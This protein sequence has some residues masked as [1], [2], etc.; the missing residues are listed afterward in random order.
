ME[1]G[2]FPAWVREHLPEPTEIQRMAWPLLRGGGSAL[3]V[4]PTGT[5]KTEAAMVPILE[6]LVEHPSLPISVVYVS[7]LRALNRDLEGRLLSMA[8]SAGL[9]AKAR[10][11]DTPSSERTRQSRNP[12]NL[13]ITTPET[14]QL[15]LIGKNLRK[16]LANARVVVIDEVHELASSDRGAQLALSLER[17]ERLAGRRVRR[18]GLSA[19]VSN[20][21]ELARFISYK[22]PA[23]IVVATG[24]KRF[25]ISVTP[26]VEPEEGAATARF[27]GEAD[28]RFLSAATGV[29]Q[30]V[31]AHE[32]TLVFT[33]TRPAAE[34][35]TAYLRRLAPDM[36]VAIHHGSLSRMVREEAE[37]EFRQG[38]TRAL[39][40]TSSLELGID[41][42]A[43]DHVVQLGSP[44]RVA[45]LVQRVGRA[46]HTREKTS[47][48]TVIA[49][50]E[51]DLEEAAVIARRALKGEVEPIVV[52]RKN[53]I[54]LAQ[55]IVALIR[56][57]GATTLGEIHEI[58]SQAL[59]S[60][61]LSA[62]EIEGL[63][64][65]LESHGI[66][67]VEGERVVSTR[68]TLDHFYSTL[69]LIP[70][71][72]SY[73]LRD[74]GTRR[75]IGN[76][77]ERFVVTRVLSK[78]DHTFLLHGTTWRM[79]SLKDD[80]LLVEAV[81]ELG[82]PPH[83]EG[84]DI[85]VPFEVAQEIGALRRTKDVS[86]YPLSVDGRGILLDRLGRYP[87]AQ[88][89]TD[90]QMTAEI[91]GSLLIL[92]TCFGSTVNNT[93]S[94]LY[95]ASATAVTGLSVESVLVT[96]VWIVL[97]MPSVP[98]REEVEKILR[99][100]PVKVQEMLLKGI[101]RTEDYRWTF[102]VVSRKLGL[103]PLNY[104]SKGNRRLEPLMDSYLDSPIGKEALAKVI[105]E[106]FDVGRTEEIL[107]DLASGKRLLEVF[108][109][110]TSTPGSDVLDR[111][112]WSEL[113]GRPPP[114]FLR[115][116]RE[117]LEKE[118]LVTICLR[119][120]FV[121]N[122]TP[123]SYPTTGSSPCMAC[124]AV[125]TAVISPRRRKEI[126]LITKYVARKKKAG[127]MGTP[128][129]PRSRE[130]KILASA[131]ASAELVATYG[132]RALFV[133]A[134]RG[135]GPETAR[136]I[137]SKG[138]GELDDLLAEIVRVEKNYAKNREFWD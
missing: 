52:R 126:E 57:K 119:C 16:G 61:D 110:S 75:L 48:G 74:M 104:D 3:L 37:I 125:M 81:Q 71:E 22:D 137:L 4:A 109:G 10:H 73:A 86:E 8:S 68:G 56:E 108:P 58:S 77:D 80:E 39:V 106:K 93:L 11:G 115:A 64:H 34:T 42:G 72:H 70:E 59:P 128:L 1:D 51:M 54:A 84:D 79:V 29:L 123:R 69:S 111:L 112:K 20:P 103:M 107:R 38:N 78:P 49:M 62:E 134:G 28:R 6:D 40:A 131:H 102:V 138:Y 116:V 82:T 83:W 17:L 122:L 100:D 60:V 66:V 97:R 14:L 98:S 5:G 101:V 90:L 35:L 130:S 9:T 32:S 26:S 105:H 50:D 92:G 113:P 19:T 118:E 129:R 23:S 91:N 2:G 117:R 41:I 47:E 133:L 53:T 94:V 95:S 24:E 18:I 136:R 65:T 30:T 132:S 13:L 31:H 99:L 36:S 120:G 121:R 55:Q 33:N 76:L 96:P 45:R 7:P 87:S 124:H 89:P 15:L 43:I 12:P 44:H 46:G 67:R 88:V 135:I 127:S 25:L 21:E 63:A 85:P 114:T 27:R